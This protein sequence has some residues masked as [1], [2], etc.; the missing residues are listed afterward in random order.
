MKARAKLASDSPLKK[1]RKSSV[2]L[3][4][5][6]WHTHKSVVVSAIVTLAVSVKACPQ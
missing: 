1:Q 6:V 3:H 4:V 2:S 5:K